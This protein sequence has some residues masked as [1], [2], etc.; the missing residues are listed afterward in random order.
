MIYIDPNDCHPLMDVSCHQ[1]LDEI[2]IIQII[3]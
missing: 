2:Y 3:G 1:F